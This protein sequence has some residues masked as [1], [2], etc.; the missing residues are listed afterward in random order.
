MGEQQADSESKHPSLPGA[1]QSHTKEK[2]GTLSENKLKRRAWASRALDK[3]TH[4]G[5]RSPV[6]TASFVAQVHPCVEETSYGEQLLDV[7]EVGV[8][9]GLAQ[10]PGAE[11]WAGRW[12]ARR[13]WVPAAQS[14]GPAEGGGRCWGPPGPSAEAR[15]RETGSDHGSAPG[16][17]R[18]TSSPGEEKS[19]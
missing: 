11:I 7:K 14:L 1:P 12:R 10:D 16:L 17:N 18:A 4:Q 9:E 5:P 15:G 2:G 8:L 13:P 6:P 3:H 19:G